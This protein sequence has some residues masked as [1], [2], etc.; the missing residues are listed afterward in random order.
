MGIEDPI[1]YDADSDFSIS[2][3]IGQLFSQQAFLAIS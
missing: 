2:V 1:D 3:S